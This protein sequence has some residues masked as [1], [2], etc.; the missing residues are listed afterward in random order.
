MISDPYAPDLQTMTSNL[1][2]GLSDR[3][4]MDKD[5]EMITESLALSDDN[6]TDIDYSTTPV[7]R[8]TAQPEEY[9]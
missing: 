3:I 7:E 9:Q 8:E 6:D 5:F 4:Q 2:S 1:Q